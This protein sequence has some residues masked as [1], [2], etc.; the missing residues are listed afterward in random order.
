[1]PAPSQ[2]S[3]PASTLSEAEMMVI[4]RCIYPSNSQA[5]DIRPDAIDFV[6]A[7]GSS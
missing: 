4:H 1:M 3:S 2:P 5:F 7:I 6:V